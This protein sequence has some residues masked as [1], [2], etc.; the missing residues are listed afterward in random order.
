MRRYAAD[1]ASPIRPAGYGPPYCSRPD[2]SYDHANHLAAGG[3]QWLSTPTKSMMRRS[4]C[5]ISRFTTATGPGR[6]LTGMRSVVCMKKGLIH[7]PV[8]K[9]KS[10]AFTVEGLE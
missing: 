6:V 4:R 10:V 8:G 9:T 5:S 3:S 1:Y 7:D 2:S